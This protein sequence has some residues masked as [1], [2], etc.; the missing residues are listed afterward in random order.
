LGT[1]AE[2]DVMRSNDH[3]DAR[4]LVC[5]TCVARVVTPDGKEVHTEVEI[6]TL[7]KV[8]LKFIKPIRSINRKMD[9]TF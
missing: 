6:T 4:D 2:R 5:P 3:P 1:W 8:S 9:S 7:F